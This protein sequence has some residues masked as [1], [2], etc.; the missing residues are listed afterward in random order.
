MVAESLTAPPA[1]GRRCEACRRHHVP[2]AF[3]PACCGCLMDAATVLDDETGELLECECGELVFWSALG[4]SGTDIGTWHGCSSCGS[5]G[6]DRRST[7][8]KSTFTT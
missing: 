7:G 3:C 4:R 2:E 1:H 6:P 5:A 8:G